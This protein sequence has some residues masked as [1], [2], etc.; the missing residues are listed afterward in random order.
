MNQEL[1]YKDRFVAFLDIL[2]FS[3]MVY[4]DSKINKAKIYFYQTQ[5]KSIVKQLKDDIEDINKIHA[6]ENKDMRIEFNHVIISDSIVLTVDIIKT[7]NRTTM[8]AADDIKSIFKQQSTLSN[9]SAK[10]L[11]EMIGNFG[12]LH[13]LYSKLNRLA[14][15]LLCEKIALLQVY[16]A[17]KDIWLRGAITSGETFI[18]VEENQ[19]IGKAYIDAYKLESNYAIYPRVIKG[20]TNFGFRISDP[21]SSFRIPQSI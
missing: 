15:A 20:H 21:Q 19:I 9:S 8:K 10:K 7:K 5:I 4:S 18:D 11:G 12:D 16:L 13:N 14:F 2:G 17:S 3:N 6:K 1:L